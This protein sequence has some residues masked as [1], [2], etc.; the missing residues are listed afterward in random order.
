MEKTCK[1]LIIGSGVA[2]YNALKELLSIRPDSRIILVSKDRN[3]PYDRPPLS[4][5]YLRGKIDK[6]MLF[7]ESPDF[8][9][10]DNLEILLNKEVLKIDIGDRVAILTDGTE[11]EFTKALIAT[12]GRPRKLNIQGEEKK[13][14]HYLRT[15]DDAD[16]IKNDV[17][18]TKT[19]VIIGGGFIGMEV[20]SSLTI[21]GLRP[22]VIE[23]KPYIWNTFVDEKISKFIQ[24]YFENKGVRF[25]IN[26]SVKEIYGSDKVDGVITESGKK[27]ET[28]FVLISAGIIPNTEIAERS[29]INVNNGITV[30]EKLETSALGIYAA[31]DVASIFEP[32]AN[33]RKRIE[34]WNNAE[35]TG[36]LVAHNMLGKEE[37][38]NF[39]STVWSDIFDLHIESAGDTMDYD[40]YLI[41]GSFEKPSF[42]VIYVKGGIVKG[43][44]SI[45]RKVKE[46]A[47]LNKIIEKKVDVSNRKNSLVDESFD[48]QK[49]LS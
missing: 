13:G 37:T 1:Y 46:I 49:L 8:Y 10:K 34:H 33:K 21:L 4:K 41:R 19:P 2:G 28:N 27:I 32:I 47:A 7:Y 17:I 25:L 29:K 15:L 3:Y 44:L 30:N 20:A 38:Y 9:K 35:Y 5:E 43:Y 26:E 40:E 18:S 48:L 12:G 42:S 6:E 36:K 23:V 31:G 22:I 16:S 39:I 14:V 45:N 11:I 24:Q